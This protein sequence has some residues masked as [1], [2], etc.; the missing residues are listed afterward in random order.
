MIIDPWGSELIEDYKRII[1]EFG[2][3]PFTEK[4]L[5]LFPEPNNLMKRFAVVGGQSLKEIANAIKHKKDFYALT[6]IMPSS[7]KL[8]FGNKM[9]V[10]NLKYFQDHGAETFVLVADLESAATKGISLKEARKRALE[11]HVP[12]YIALG[13]N[14]KKTVFY[15][16]SKN[17]KVKNFGYLFSKKITLNEFRAIYGDAH[18][19]RIVS[20]LIQAADILFPQ[21]EKPRFGV[22]P[23]GIDQSP[24]IR[25]TRDI[26]RRT[27]K[28][29]NFVLP[30]GFYHKYTPS[31]NGEMKMSKS[32]PQYNIDIPEEPES[33][34][35]KL[36]NALTGGRETAEIQRKLG[37]QPEKCMVFE[38]DKLHLLNDKEL[39]D[40]FDKCVSGER[41]CGECKQIAMNA[42]KKYLTQ[43]VKDFNKA[44]KLVSK[45][46]FVEN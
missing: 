34:A 38:M 15:F 5:S 41:L 20:A 45:L 2:M 29:F 31:L 40:V 19:S 16:Q 33:A 4:I 35:R 6:G 12:A 32:F 23:V 9:V 7:E 44:K 43:F 46:K 37:G 1:K 13:L 28:Q 14:P 27:K 30:A 3:E 22:I 21:F 39:K 11:F 26:V 17:E 18:P 10:E 8:H 36:K 42:M 24:H 25:L